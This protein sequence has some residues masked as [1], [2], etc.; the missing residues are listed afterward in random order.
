M[1]DKAVL[2]LGVVIF[3]HKVKSVQ[4]L[5]EILL[6]MQCDDLATGGYWLWD[7]QLEQVYYSPKFCA[8]LGFNYNDFGNSF[9]GFNHSNNEELL[10]GLKMIDELITNKSNECFINNVTYYNKDNKSVNVIC[11]GTVFYKDNEPT[12]IL[13]THK[14]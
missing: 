1:H 9:E 5:G 13:G 6:D 14:V 11:S 2:K 10:T 4:E 7:Y 8:S 3:E 12:Y